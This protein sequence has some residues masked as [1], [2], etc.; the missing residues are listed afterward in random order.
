LKT[1]LVSSSAAP[2]VPLQQLAVTEFVL[3]GGRRA[4]F[5]GM[6]HLFK[7]SMKHHQ[8]QNCV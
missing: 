8:Q 1:A 3:A 7:A 5:K 2:K 4:S 6:P